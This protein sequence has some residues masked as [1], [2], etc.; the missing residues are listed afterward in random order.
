MS[1]KILAVAL[2]A[3][4]ILG[5]ASVAFAASFTDIEGHAREGAIERLKG[6]GLIDGYGDGTF[7]PDGSI[8]RAEVSK[9]IVFAMGLKDAAEMLEGVP[10]GFADVA[11]NHW[12]TGY[13]SVASTQGIVKGYPDGTFQPENKVTYAE[14]LTMILR[15]LGYG[16]ALDHLPWPNAYI[17]KAAELKINKGVSF[18][19]NSPAT[20]GDVAA[21]LAN[22]M[23]VPKLVQVTYGDSVRY[24]VS[25]TEGTK[26]VTLLNDMGAVSKMGWLVVS[27]DLFSWDDGEPIVLDEVVEDEDDNT[28]EHDVPFYLAEGTECVGLLGHYVRVWL[29]E[30][31]EVFYVEDLTPATAIKTASRVSGDSRKVKY[32][33]KVKSIPDTAVMFRNHAVDTSKTTQ[34]GDEITVILD[35][36]AIK[37]LVVKNYKW[38][39]VDTVNT[40][41]E[42]IVFDGSSNDSAITLKGFDVTW[43]GAASSLEDLEENDVVQYIKDDTEKKAVLVVTRNSVVGKFEKL[44]GDSVKTVTVDGSEYREPEVASG[45]KSVGISASNLGKEVT[46][47]LNKD[48]KVV[49][50][51]AATTTST[52]TLAVVTGKSKSEDEWDPA[53]EVYKLRLFGTDGKTVVLE[54][55]P[56]VAEYDVDGKQTDADPNA[57]GIQNP[58]A[59]AVYQEIKIGD[60]IAYKTNSRG[61][62]NYVAYKVR[63]TPP[64]SEDPAANER[65]DIDRDYALIERTVSGPSVKITADTV[66]FDITDPTDPD[67]LDVEDLL[68]NEWITGGV[69]H[70]AG[71]ATVV[72]ITKA[73]LAADTNLYAMVYGMYQGPKGSSYSWFLRLL[74]EGVVS[75]YATDSVSGLKTK[76]VIKFTLRGGEI[77][78]FE[79]LSEVRP[80]TI[81]TV[82]EDLRITEIDLENKLITVQGFRRSDGSDVE[83]TEWFLLVDDDTLFYDVTGSSPKSIELV[84]LSV[85]AK[86]RV[87]TDDGTV[88]GD[89]VAV[90]VLQ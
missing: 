32:D 89:V 73:Q 16:P 38:G 72:G 36:G 90:V 61:K 25:G 58:E 67:V 80:D 60:I 43:L 85:M 79:K 26:A 63:Y 10:V 11:A 17:A 56:N 55:A 12:A 3:A 2:A 37:Y 78:S 83:G 77:D 19:A 84:D 71:K 28:P 22:A 74:A 15:A 21:L 5:L 41:Y 45:N 24:V 68:A 65:L 70:S 52:S 69:A 18:N 29:N 31:E 27:P 82:Y 59:S 8:T 44:S 34:P 66:V 35:D 30:D 64:T 75:D 76:D 88:D 13:I 51:I 39:V 33:G 50:M 40:T 54:L 49:K 46:L 42:R 53:V 1:K 57:E 62:I 86:V 20:R 6:L 14:I 23:T 4:M 47:L 87:Y 81:N 9:L 7:R 48:G